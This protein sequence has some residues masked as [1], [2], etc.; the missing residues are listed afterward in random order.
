MEVDRLLSE[1]KREGEPVKIE[2]VGSEDGE[3]CSS[4]GGKN[5]EEKDLEPE[6][7]VKQEEGDNEALQKDETHESHSADPSSSEVKSP[8]SQPSF[9]PPPPPEPKEEPCPKTSAFSPPASIRL[10]QPFLP[11]SNPLPMVGGLGGGNGGHSTSGSSVGDG[12]PPPRERSPHEQQQQQQQQQQQLHQRP[13]PPV[14]PLPF[15]IDNILQPSFGQSLFLH[16]VAAAA[17]AVATAQ[18]NAAVAAAVA[19]AAAGEGPPPPVGAVG[20]APNLFHLGKPNF[21]H[22]QPRIGGL[23]IVPPSP[24]F[25]AAAAHPHPPAP[26][27]SSPSP[28]S[29]SPGLTLLGQDSIKREQVESPL[30][31]GS[32]GGGTSNNNNGKRSLP[33]P[34]AA[35][36]SG[37]PVD[38]SSKNGEADGSKEGGGGDKGKDGDCPPGMVRGPNGQLWPAWVFCTRYSDRPSSGKYNFEK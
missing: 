3:I 13:A 17:A 23:P 5:A 35:S 7:A 31:N 20:G 6:P 16:R 29:P 37:K 9:S 14:P 12:S 28:S 4:S 24:A 19:A 26:S 38:L 25:A 22:P 21:H 2:K 33:S 11:N 10:F 15:S 30:S 27:S 18:K 32:E 36:A 1:D 34:S 8:P